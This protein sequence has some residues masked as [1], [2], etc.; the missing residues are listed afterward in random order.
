VA[1]T[2]VPAPETFPI[3]ADDRHFEVVIA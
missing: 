2:S 3:V 1:V